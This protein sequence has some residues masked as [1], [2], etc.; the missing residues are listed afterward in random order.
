[1]KLFQS[2]LF[3][4]FCA[5]AIGVFIL[6]QPDA[7]VQYLTI[8][9]GVLFLISGVVSCL[10]YFYTISHWQ[11]RK[12]VDSEGNVYDVRKPWFPIGGVGSILLGFILALM[13]SMFVKSLIYVLAIVVIVG[14]LHQIFMLVGATRHFAMSGSFWILPIILLVAGIVMLIKPMMVAATPLLVLAICLIIYGVSDCIN[15][16]A[17]HFKR[18]KHIR[19]QLPME[20]GEYVEFEE[21]KDDSLTTT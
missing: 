5:I 14:A 8:A 13:P 11:D 10:A 3:R 19:T 7:T 4:A 16:L 6:L 9:L 21:V 18:K 1:M 17:I 15:S 20:H 2:S 12:E